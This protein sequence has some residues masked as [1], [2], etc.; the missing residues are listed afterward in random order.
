MGKFFSYKNRPMQFGA[1]PLEKLARQ[2]TPLGLGDIAPMAPV[3]FRRPEDPASIVN[4]MQ[5]YQAMLDATRSGAAKPEVATLPPDVKERANHL[6]S[7]GYYCDSAM[8]GIAKITPEA[9]L[10]TPLENPDVVRL[11][12]KLNTLQPKT[13]ASGIDVI[14]AG[15]REN[16]AAPRRDCRHLNR[17][18]LAQPIENITAPHLRQRC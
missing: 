15:L 16:L 6:K 4:A 7:F 13:F 5:E 11:A 14:M 18:G 8:V 1:Y 9:W 3:S 2:S 17:S 12:E 10:G